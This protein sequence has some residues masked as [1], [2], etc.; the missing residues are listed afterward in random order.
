MRALICTGPARAIIGETS[1]RPL[2]NGE[3]RIAVKAA[4]LSFADV[5]IARGAYQVR[6]EYPFVPGACGCGVVTESQAPNALHVGE[7]VSFLGLNGA[8]AEEIVVPVESV[9][10][11]IPGLAPEKVAAL[12]LFYPPV[13]FALAS[14]AGLGAGETLLVTGAGGASGLAAIEI[15]KLLGARILAGASSDSKL[16]MALRAG[17]DVLINYAAEDLV[18]RVHD[19][20]NGRGVNVVFDVV[21]GEVFSQAVRCAA[22]FARIVVYGFASGDIPLL[23]VNRLLLKNRTLLGASFGGVATGWDHPL[24]RK[25]YDRIRAW[26]DSRTLAAPAVAVV[27]FERA[28]QVLNAFLNGEEHPPRAII[29]E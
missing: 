6:A 13:D 23:R 11:G 29:F 18:A 12:R 15:G 27:P 8:C 14:R 19:S 9:A 1:T 3:V 25:S 10:R 4:L 24:A 17:A 2:R 28:D 16:E 7:T 5:L 20:T 26:A 22:E 21:G